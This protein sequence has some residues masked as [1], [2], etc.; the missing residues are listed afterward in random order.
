M[1]GFMKLGI[2]IIKIGRNNDDININWVLCCK[3]NGT[4]FADKV[5]E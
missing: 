1:I 3:G 2:L 4:L 5:H